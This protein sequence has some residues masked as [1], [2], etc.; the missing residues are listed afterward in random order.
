MRAI[1][2]LLGQPPAELLHRVV[3]RPCDAAQLVVAVIETR[4]A[5]VAG[6]VALGDLRN[7]AHAAADPRRHD[8]GDGGRA[9]HRQAER[10]ERRGSMRLELLTDAR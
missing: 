1:A 7:G 2:R 8:P 4:R 5:E 3:Q 10:R 6:A 9:D